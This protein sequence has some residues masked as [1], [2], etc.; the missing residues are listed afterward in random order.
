MCVLHVLLRNIAIYGGQ[1][2]ARVQIGLFTLPSALPL[3]G[4]VL[5]VLVVGEAV[6]AVAAPGGLRQR[7]VAHRLLPLGVDD[8]D[9]PRVLVGK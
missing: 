2:N 5:L 7:D 1:G 9:H 8:P 3:S 4:Q 6:D